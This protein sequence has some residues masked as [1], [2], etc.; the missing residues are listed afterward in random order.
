MEISRNTT[1][2]TNKRRLSKITD[3][4]R[5]DLK[6]R[7]EEWKP[8]KMDNLNWQIPRWKFAAP[9]SAFAETDEAFRSIITDNQD[10]I[11]ELNEIENIDEF[12]YQSFEFIKKQM[13]IENFSVKLVITDD[14]NCY[15]HTDNSVHISRNRAW[16]TK[17]HI[18][19]WWD[20]S[21][22]FAWIVHEMVHRLEHK[23]I[24]LN[25]QAED[26]KVAIHWRENK[27]RFDFIDEW[28]SAGNTTPENVD[29]ILTKSD[30]WEN[31]PGSKEFK[32]AEKY[33]NNWIRWYKSP[34]YKKWKR[35]GQTKKGKWYEKYRRQPVETRAMRIGEM[36]AREYRK[37]IA[38]SKKHT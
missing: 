21:E 7:L 10:K 34:F 15:N 11:I 31:Q 32:K 9:N 18:P 28:I 1:E 8:V 27:T 38:S 33:A 2:N 29:E 30:Y 3:Q 26:E 24:I 12:C 35:K 17:K 16:L 6:K 14:D 23:E 22:I 19:W 37:A 36:M 20:K 25:A 5:R 4:T 13:W